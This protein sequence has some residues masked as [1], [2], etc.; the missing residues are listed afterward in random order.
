M[1]SSYGP[2]RLGPIDIFIAVNALR[3]LMLPITSRLFWVTFFAASVLLV[4]W[5][6]SIGDPIGIS[7]V[8]GV[9]LWT[10][11]VSPALS[12]LRTTEVAL[13]MTDAGLLAVTNQIENL[14]KDIDASRMRTVLGR[15]LIPVSNQCV[16]IVPQQA[17]GAKN[18]EKL[19]AELIA[20]AARHQPA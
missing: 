11:I 13:R 3:F 2:Y 14:Y 15:L 17:V 4:G 8:T 12:G 1:Q 20:F 16:V 9:F 19:R 7:A 18:L 10:L 5:I 6:I